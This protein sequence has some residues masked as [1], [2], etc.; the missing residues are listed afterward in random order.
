MYVVK[1]NSRREKQVIVLVIPNGE[2]WHQITVKEFPAL[3]R[4]KTSKYRRGFNC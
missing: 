4:G 1:H 3:F 2:G